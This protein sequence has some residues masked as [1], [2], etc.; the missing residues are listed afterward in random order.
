MA[1]TALRRSVLALAATSLA[2]CLVHCSTSGSTDPAEGNDESLKS[3][4]KGRR[5][6]DGGASGTDAGPAIDSGADAPAI[7]ASTSDAGVCG[8]WTMAAARSLAAG[9]N[10]DIHPR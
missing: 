5:C 6:T 2:A 7:D 9:A 1:P 8:T 3:S 4:C 10:V